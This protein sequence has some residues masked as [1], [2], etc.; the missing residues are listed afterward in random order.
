MSLDKPLDLE[1]IGKGAYGIIM[2]KKTNNLIYV[3]KQFRVE[4]YN[5]NTS[6]FD[7]E[8][9]YA[10]LA[11]NINTDIFINIL[12]DEISNFFFFNSPLDLLKMPS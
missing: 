7:K 1:F 6:S 12:K 5:N 3:I 2:K 10:K 4:Y 8:V 11:Y 9:K